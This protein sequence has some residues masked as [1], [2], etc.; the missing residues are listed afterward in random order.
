MDV[1]SQQFTQSFNF[2][3]C[4]HFFL[5]IM[6]LE[7]AM[8]FEDCNCKIFTNIHLQ[9]IMQLLGIVKQ[10]ILE[11]NKLNKIQIMWQM[12]IYECPYHIPDDL[13]V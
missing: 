10:Y 9:V 2:E 13:T 7:Y 11:Q 3:I 4:K 5:A 8:I 12:S 1:L 6:F